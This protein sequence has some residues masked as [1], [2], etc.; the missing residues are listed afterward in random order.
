MP[1]KPV[2]KVWSFHGLVSMKTY[3]SLYYKKTKY[4]AEEELWLLGLPAKTF[5]VLEF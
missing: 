1:G 2:E 3:M 5:T 4:H